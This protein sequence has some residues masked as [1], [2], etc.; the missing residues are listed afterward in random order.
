MM[1]RQQACRYKWDFHTK[2]HQL[3]HV[4]RDVLEAGSNPRDAWT[5]AN[6]SEIGAAVSVAE[7]CH[8]ST[9]LRMVIRRHRLL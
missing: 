7:A 2:M 1:M 8:A 6:E 9:V 5:Y 3:M 4:L